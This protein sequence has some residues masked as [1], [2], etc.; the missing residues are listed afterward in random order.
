MLF[1][2]CLRSDVSV[3]IILHWCHIDGLLTLL[4]LRHYLDLPS[5]MN[6]YSHC[7]SSIALPPCGC[8]PQTTKSVTHYIPE[9]PFMVA[10]F[11]TLGLCLLMMDIL[12]VE[13]L[14]H[15]FFA[16]IFHAR[17]FILDTLSIL[18]KL[19]LPKWEIHLRE[20]PFHF[21]WK[22]LPPFWSSFNTLKITS[23]LVVWDWLIMPAMG[24]PYSFCLGPN[25]LFW[26]T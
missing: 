23:L 2:P 14:L 7:S 13:A 3:K 19:T 4:R 16:L 25:T 15:L 20:N 18:L 1:P 8:P 21:A 5:L 6:T 12:W 26:A 11:T 24:M 9:P 10:W 22:P 17:S